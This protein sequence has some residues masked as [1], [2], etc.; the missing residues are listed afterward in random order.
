MFK[1]SIGLLVATGLMPAATVTY[2]YDASGRLTSA[3][4]D[5]GTAVTYAYDKASNLLG[6]TVPG[7]TPQIKLNAVGNSATY[8]APLVR[9]ELATIYG[10]NLSLTTGSILSLPV[11]FTMGGVQVTVAGFP[12]PVYYV[13]P[14]QINFQV[15]FEAPTT[16]NVPVVTKLYGS[17]SPAQ[18]VPMAEYAPGIFAYVRTAGVIDPI[19]VHS[20]N[21]TL[22]TP[23]NPASSGEGLTIYGT[24]AGT[25]DFPP[26]TGA[27]ASGSTLA[28]T[29]ITPS[30]TVGGA[31]AQ[32]LFAGLAPGYVGLLQINITLPPTLPSGTLPM[33]IQFGTTAAPQVNL[34][35]K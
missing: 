32:V 2:Q 19:V 8:T 27:A 18:L 6:R 3:A 33:L 31:G 25:F 21:Y 17:A 7:P 9:G 22:V 10:S 26:P 11:P 34:Y 23:D 13:S 35:V 14:S 20:A 30:V 1:I 4:Y 16:G 12:A 5:N 15:P 29:K 24:G 28:Q